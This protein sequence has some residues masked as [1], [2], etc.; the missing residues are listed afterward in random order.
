[1]QHDL[2]MILEWKLSKARFEVTSLASKHSPGHDAKL[3]KFLLA[4][5]P[6]SL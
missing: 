6:I 5:N 3:S 2:S 4:L 1:M